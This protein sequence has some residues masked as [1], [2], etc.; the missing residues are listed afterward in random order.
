MTHCSL[1]KEVAQRIVQNAQSSQN[2]AL[3]PALKSAPG[4]RSSESAQMSGSTFSP[5]PL[6]SPTDKSALIQG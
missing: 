6:T 3:S 5:R 4:M 1:F 2:D